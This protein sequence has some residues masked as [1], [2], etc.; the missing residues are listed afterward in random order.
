M[1]FPRWPEVFR[2]HSS[3]EVEHYLVFFTH[4]ALPML[5][6]PADK[7]YHQRRRP[8]RVAHTPAIGK[9]VALQMQFP[10]N[11]RIHSFSPQN[12]QQLTRYMKNQGDGKDGKHGAIQ[13]WLW[14]AFNANSGDT[15]GIVRFLPPHA[16]LLGMHILYAPRAIL[17]SG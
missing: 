4:K 10:S 16:L 14:W 13:H 5:T 6:I 9:R 17:G 7:P 15:G 1:D 2:Q 11:R 8:H 12:L 3:P